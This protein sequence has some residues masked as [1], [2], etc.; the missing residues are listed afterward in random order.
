[1]DIFV[2]NQTLTNGI[3]SFNPVPENLKRGKTLDPYLRELLAEQD[4]YICL[5]QDKTLGN[6]QQRIAFVYGPLTKIW[7]AME[8]EKESYLAEE[9]EANPL[10]EMSKLF[11]QVVL[12]L[13]QAMNSCSYIRRFN[14]LMSFL[15][16]KKRVESMLQDNAAVFSDAWNMLFGSK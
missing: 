14:V 1:M 12:L 4:K 15:G 6:L 11:D 13:G 16:D 9:G 7:T 2:S 5:N 8:A 10:F 3:M